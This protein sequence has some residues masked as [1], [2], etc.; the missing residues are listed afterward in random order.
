MVGYM[1]E[2][3][4]RETPYSAKKAKAL[5][6]AKERASRL[7]NGI[8]DAGL[9]PEDKEAIIKEIAKLFNPCTT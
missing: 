3:R 1:T 8:K 7:L 4:Y 5:N 2:I 6:K 9:K